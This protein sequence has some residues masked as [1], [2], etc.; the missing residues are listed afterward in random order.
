[1]VHAIVDP[2]SFPNNKFGIHII[3]PT[4]QEVADATNLVNS[5]GGDWGYVTFLIES[6]DRNKDKWQE[7]FNELRRRHLIPIVR[8]A[9]KPLNAHWERPGLEDAQKWAQFLNSLNWP[10][11]NR[12]I[13]VYNEPNH[14]KEWGQEVSP[15][16]YAQVL[17]ETINAL[18]QASPDFFVLNAG[19][20]ASSPHLPPRSFDEEK[21]LQEMENSV[22]G[23]FQKLDGWASHSYPNPGF[24]GLPN[25]EGRGSVAGFWW[26]MQTLKKL[27][28]RK[29]LPIFI[30]E[31]G[32]MHAEGIADNKSLPTSEIVGQFLQ[33]VFQNAW[34]SPSI[35]AVTPFLLNYQEAPFDHFSFKEYASADY[36]PQ[37]QLVADMPKIKGQPVQEN[38]AELTK[39]EVYHSMVALQEYNIRLEFKNSGQSIWSP[40]AGSGQAKLVALQGGKELGIEDVVVENQVEPQQKYT[41]NVK[42]KAPREGIHKVVMNL[43]QDGKQFET[44]PL[45]WTTQVKSP[46]ILIVK[47]GMNWKRTHQG[48]YYLETRGVSGESVR[49]VALEQEGSSKQL[50]A[51]YLLPDYEFEFTLSKPHYQSKTIRVKLQSGENVLDFGKLDPDILGTLLNPQEL[52]QLLPFSN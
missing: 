30:T 49:L 25:D 10:V 38:K 3:S 8:L 41:F 14:G 6:G 11:K 23:I 32:W 24:V 22:P 18:K 37:Y 27:G 47:G 34:N 31:T 51:N 21:F 26:E 15:A 1:M 39:G 20:D 48:D 4:P 28:L 5:S 9:T 17:N 7:F 33:N 45:E 36:Y 35:V 46:V 43:M 44:P 42:L 16:S 2:L 50:E 19:F 12:Y 29:N 13:V 52:W 40:S